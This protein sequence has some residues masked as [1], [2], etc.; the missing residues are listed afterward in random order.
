MSNQEAEDFCSRWILCCN[1]ISDV[2]KAS[3]QALYWE[4]ET[5]GISKLHLSPIP[6]AVF[7][8]VFRQGSFAVMYVLLCVKPSSN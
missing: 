4:R 7:S 5:C 3:K 2:K 1:E 6:C 8:F